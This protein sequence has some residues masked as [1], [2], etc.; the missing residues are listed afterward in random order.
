MIT[1]PSGRIVEISQSTFQRLNDE[2]LD[3]VQLEA[4]ANG[5]RNYTGLMR[6]HSELSEGSPKRWVTMKRPR[7]A[8]T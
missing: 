5:L 4:P 7:A 3:A 1:K 2:L 6:F 8:T